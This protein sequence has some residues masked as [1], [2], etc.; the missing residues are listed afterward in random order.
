MYTPFYATKLYCSKGLRSFL[1]VFVSSVKK[2]WNTVFIKYK[3]INDAYRIKLLEAQM[4]LQL[5]SL[6][7]KLPNIEQLLKEVI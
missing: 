6:R 7:I 3:V 2:V 5:C 4:Q 1:K